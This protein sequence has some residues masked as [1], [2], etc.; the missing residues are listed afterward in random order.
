MANPPHISFNPCSFHKAADKM[1][2]VCLKLYNSDGS[3]SLME[4][5]GGTKTPPTG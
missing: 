1:A 5:A 4:D 3:R 2:A